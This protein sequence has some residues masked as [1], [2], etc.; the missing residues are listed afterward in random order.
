MLKSV[1]S[2][3]S[4]GIR[5]GEGFNERRR[6]RSLADNS[7]SIMM[8]GTEAADAATAAND[9]AD[10]ALAAVDGDAGNRDSIAFGKDNTRESSRANASC[11]D[12]DDNN[13]GGDR[14]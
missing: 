2:P 6:A 9:D 3:S 1:T 4:V 10:A 14:G 7:G 11:M 8:I 12:G 13:D 5:S